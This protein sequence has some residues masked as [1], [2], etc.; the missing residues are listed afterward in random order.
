MTVA[1]TVSA[2]AHRR[3]PAGT[4]RPG[5]ADDDR[6]HARV[7]AGAGVPLRE[8][9]RP[10]VT[11]STFEEMAVA[12]LDPVGAQDRPVDLL[13]LA[14]ATPDLHPLTLT[15]PTLAAR[16]P[17]RPRLFG[18]TDTGVSA[19]FTMLALARSSVLRHRLRR[20][21]AFAFDQSDLPYDASPPPDRRV[22]G[23]AA[24]ALVVEPAPDGAPDG[25]QVRQ[26]AGIPAE[27]VPRTLDSLAA[28]LAADGASTVLV[29]AGVGERWQP[30]I[31][32]AALRHTPEG[33][34]CTALFGALAALRPAPD[35][36]PVLLA[37]YDRSLGDLSVCCIGPVAA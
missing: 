20:V 13:L 12:L 33:W 11:G 1:L 10:T 24:V 4:T 25:L 16:L 18:V 30:K 6:Y 32:H 17:G 14:Y 19:P 28:E 3:F 23:D 7:A 36:A 34:P 29:G 27:E 31:P 8:A 37:E 15:G 21:L 9:A 5:A 35:D 26:R 22:A 2:T